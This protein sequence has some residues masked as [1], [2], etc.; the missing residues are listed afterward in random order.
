M[1]TASKTLVLIGY[2][3]FVDC[4]LYAS[5]VCYKIC[6]ISIFYLL[7]LHKSAGEDFIQ[8]FDLSVIPKNH[9]ADNCHDDSDAMPSLIYRGRNDYVLSL[10]TLLYRIA[11]RLSLS[12]VFCKSPIVRFMLYHLLL[13]DYSLLAVF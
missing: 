12:M 13:P 5:F 10:G 4:L 1:K 8:L 3:Y 11:H 9:C 6:F 7:Q 2:L